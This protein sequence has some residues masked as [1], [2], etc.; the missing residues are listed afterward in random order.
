MGPA[1][2]DGYHPLRSLM[3]A[4]E[5]L[6][7]TV[8]VALAPSGGRQVRCPGLDG[9]AN[10]AWRALDALEAEAGR[11][12]PAVVDI[13]KRIPSQAGLGGGSSDAAAV[14][15]A[16]DALHGLRLG[17]DRL[18]AVGARVG[19]DVP[20]FIRAGAQWAEGRGERL[21]PACCPPFAALLVKPDAGLPTA[22][23]YRAFD[24]LPAPPPGDGAGADVPADAAR[25]PG[26]VRNDLWPAALALRPALGVTARA[27]AAAGAPAVL[28]CGSG[29]CMAGLF[30]DAA[31]ARSAAARLPAAA[32]AF[33]A[34]VRGAPA[35][36]RPPL[37]AA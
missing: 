25:L 12:L 35:P 14:L 7:D 1:G 22:D 11:P 10:L 5:G 16:A 20:F 4:L 36:R 27:L 13:E 32:G 31:A 29:T 23:V 8:T 9:A 33:R 21:R 30:P 2:A 15:L 28:L 6:E 26:W 3:V 18:E 17:A 19:A 37:P 34:V 24:R